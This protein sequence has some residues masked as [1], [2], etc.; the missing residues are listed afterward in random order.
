[1]PRDRKEQSTN[2]NDAEEMKFKRSKIKKAD[3]TSSVICARAKEFYEM[4]CKIEDNSLK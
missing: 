2:K 4:F 1:M 3:I